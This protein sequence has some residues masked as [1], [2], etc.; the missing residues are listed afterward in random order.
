MKNLYQLSICKL[1]LLGLLIVLSCN[2]QGQANIRLDLWRNVSG[3]GGSVSNYPVWIHYGA[4]LNY[5]SSGY[6]N[7]SGEFIDTL[8]TITGS[9]S[10]TFLTFNCQGNY[11]TGQKTLTSG[12]FSPGDTLIVGCISPKPT[13]TAFA[14]ATPNGTVPQSFNF[15]G[16]YTD[17]ALGSNR[18][19]I[20]NWNFGDGQSLGGNQSV[21]HTYTNPGFY[22]ACYTVT[23]FDTLY[24]ITL[25]SDTKCVSVAAT[26]G[27]SG[28]Q[29]AFAYFTSPSTPIINFSDSTTVSS[30]PTGGSV[31]YGWSFGD[32]NMS[33]SRSTSHT[34]TTPGTYQVCH[35][36]NVKNAQGTIV[37][38]DTL[39]KNVTYSNSGGCQADF[40]YTNNPSS[41]ALFNFMD[42]SI[43][44]SVPIGGRV[45]YGWNFGDG[46]SDTNQSAN[47][48]YTTSG[49]YQVCHWVNVFNSGGSLVCLDTVCKNVTYTSSSPITCSA[50]FSSTPDSSQALG[51]LFF[52]NSTIIAS[53]QPYTVLIEWN[54]GDGDTAITNGNASHVYNAPGTYNVCMYLYV[55]SNQQVVC[56]STSCN[57]ITVTAA[58]TPFCNASYIVDTANSYFGNVYI[59]NNSTPANA[60]PIHVTSYLWDFGDG[61]TSSQPFPTH[62]YS[63]PG[64]Y[65]VC[66][67]INSIDTLGKTCSDTF[68]DSLGVDANGNLLYKANTTFTLNVLDPA[69]IGLKEHLVNEFKIYPNPAT[70]KIT[71]A[72]DQLTGE[73]LTWNITDLKGA[74]LMEGKHEVSGREKMQIDIS[75]LHSGVY[76]LSAQIDKNNPLHYKLRIE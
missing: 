38:A 50:N 3:T 58:P 56:T 48:T 19:Y 6:T 76:I 2:M 54:F 20:Y 24:G 43:V 60:S 35:W 36:V 70:D 30:V 69:K 39:C 9:V 33:T 26:S 44:S 4:P 27:T 68:C 1:A 31:S 14:N 29:S 47:H 42:S 66:L 18:V 74:V 67:T 71:L 72:W 63:S 10:T 73:T 41:P 37:C 28:C 25:F 12:M 32:G 61:I 13:L 11:I 64:Y 7:A 51:Y 23:V 62:T 53:G 22:T 8:T 57:T 5:T 45:R 46:T 34:Y 15:N 65:G 40:R 49:T 59:W 55:Y 52:N 17:T 21:T 16:S 75:R